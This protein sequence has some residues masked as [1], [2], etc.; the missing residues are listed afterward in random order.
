L[1][2]EN[3]FFPFYRSRRGKFLRIA[4]GDLPRLCSSNPDLGSCWG[5][6]EGDGLNESDLGFTLGGGVKFVILDVI[7]LK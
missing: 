3:D 4:P 1:I 2:G 7:G 5:E 6:G